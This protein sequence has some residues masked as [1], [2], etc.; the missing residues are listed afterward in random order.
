MSSGPDEDFSPRSSAEVVDNF[1]RLYYGSDVWRETF[2]MG[3]RT[4]KCPLDLWV[5]Q[6]ILSELRPGLIVESGTAWGGSALF[7][8]SMCDLLGTGRVLTVDVEHS[9]ER[10]VHPR[11]TYLHGSST[12][13]DIVA[14]VRANAA[15]VASVIVIL[16]SDHSYDHVRSELVAYAPI[17]SPGSYLIVEDSNINGHPVMPEFGPGPWEAT[18]EFL[19]EDADFTLDRSRE[20]FLLTFNPRG[21]LKRRTP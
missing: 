16:D 4:A 13:P 1:H 21:F 9:D 3:V 14:E 11:I 7:L 5:Y 2:W 10:P 18:Q 19:E 20:K 17:V 12:A 6:E 15:Q 8:A